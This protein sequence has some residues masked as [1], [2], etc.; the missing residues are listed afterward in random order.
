MQWFVMTSL[1]LR[2]LIGIWMIL[3]GYEVSQFAGRHREG[4]KQVPKE[5]VRTWMVAFPYWIWTLAGSML[6]YVFANIELFFVGSAYMQV[7]G[8]LVWIPVC[9]A[10]T[11]IWWLIRQ[12]NKA[13]EIE[14]AEERRTQ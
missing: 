1:S 6:Y 14:D 7:F 4:I 12:M 13:A 11:Y 2:F 10:S 9:P 8:V 3:I 5:L